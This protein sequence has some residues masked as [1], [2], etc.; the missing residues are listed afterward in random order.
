MPTVPRAQRQIRTDPLP[1][2]RRTAAETSTSTG[3]GLD[4]ARA[5][6]L[7]TIAQVAGGIAQIGVEQFAHIQQQERNRADDVAL[8]AAKNQIARWETDRLYTEKTGALA[9]LGKAALG[10]PEQLDAEFTALT[11]SIETGLNERQ[12]AAFQGI[13]GQA[14]VGI[15]ATIQRH[16]FEQMQ[17]YESDE[18][19]AR[20]ETGLSLI[21]ANANDPRRVGV[22]LADL[23]GDLK[24]SAPRLGLGPDAQQAEVEK[25]TTSAHVGVIE[26]LLA[27]DQ[28][29]KAR[30]YFEEAKDK[31][32]GGA[33]ARIEK[34]LD[35]ATTAGDGLRASEALWTQLGPKDADDPINLDAMETAARQQF[36][37]D[38]KTLDATIQRLR[39]RK[40]GVDAGRADR[41]EAVA[42]NLWKAVAAGAT[43][44][45]VQRMP[46]YL[47]APGALQVSVSE[48]I[49][50][51]AEQRANRAYTLGQRGEAAIAREENEKE[52]KGWALL[53]TLDTPATLAKMSDNQILAMTPGLGI[54][55][56]NR[57]LTKKRA[58]I[59]SDDTVRAATIDDDLFKTTA[60]SA[61]LKAYAPPNDAAKSA[62]GQLRNAVETAIDLEQQRSGKALTRD[63][64][65]AIM[66]SLVD[67]KVMLDVWGPDPSK[68][69]A[70]VVDP[71]DRKR[72]Y[73]PIESIQPAVIAA[74][75][76]V[77]RSDN[78]QATTGKDDDKLR[79]QYA[80]RLQRAYAVRL[81]G[82]T[83]ADITAALKGQD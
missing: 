2:V 24:K 41:K 50:E 12:R 1:G 67:Q 44:A 16:V 43:L 26:R 23:V 82:G 72:A 53:W 61:G 71:A 75:L 74:Y 28:D 7:G 81:L 58:L 64:K 79:A 62:L 20:R 38:P 56:V 69:A 10:L 66:R 77:I 57:L 55:H 63:T 47:N 52:R 65:Q 36:A 60:E 18:L 59:K 78:P 15:H 54:E 9:Q 30:I 32:S 29:K 39:E 14:G 80:S 8:M 83:T 22:E 42:G 3:A 31:I 40:S 25:L 27:T 34:A 6:K 51:A 68:V 49:V 13:K 48:H 73:V 4:Q 37:N 46:E 11:G 35:T 45:D 5:Q 21:V 17:K 70:M 19:A 76:N 33:L